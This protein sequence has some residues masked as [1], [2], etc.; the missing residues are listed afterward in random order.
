MYKTCYMKQGLVKQ[1][2]SKNECQQRML[3]FSS[4][5]NSTGFCSRHCVILHCDQQLWSKHKIHSLLKLGRNFIWWERKDYAVNWATSRKM[6]ISAA[7]YKDIDPLET[8][9]HQWWFWFSQTSMN[10]AY[11]HRAVRKKRGAFSWKAVT[12]EE[13]RVVCNNISHPSLRTWEKVANDPKLRESGKVSPSS[14]KLRQFG[15]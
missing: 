4:W 12:T 5:W 7:K 6:P 11:T 1:E 3:L 10:A 2:N 8:S 15:E 9:P 14:R 13:Y